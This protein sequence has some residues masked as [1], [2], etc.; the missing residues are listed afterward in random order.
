MTKTYMLS[1]EL[2]KPI[3]VREVWAHNL[4]YEFHL[5]REVLG[6]Y[7]LVSIDTEFPGVIIH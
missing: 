4:E 5:I 7:S 2:S 3:I 6:E 1:G